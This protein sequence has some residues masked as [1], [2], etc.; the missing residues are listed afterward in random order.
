[1]LL[2]DARERLLLFRFTDRV[3]GTSFW[4]TP[5]GGLD[6]AESFVQAAERELHEETGLRLSSPLGPHIWERS[7]TVRWGTRCFLQYERFFVHRVDHHHVSDAG[8]MDYERDELVEHR[9]WAAHEIA[10][11]SARFAPAKLAELLPLVLAGQSLPPPPLHL[12][13]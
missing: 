8:L 12:D 10:A 7:V 6:G 5:G 2:I 9:W 4:V 11:S 13:D 1:M 3:H